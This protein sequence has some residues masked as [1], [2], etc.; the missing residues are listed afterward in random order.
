MKY[1]NYGDRTD[2]LQSFRKARSVVIEGHKLLIFADLSAGVS[3]KRKDFQPV[4][5][6]LFKCNVNF[7][8][9]YPAVLCLQAL[10]GEQLTF[11]SPDKATAFLCILLSLTKPP[12]S[13]TYAEKVKSGLRE[14]RSPR[15]DLPKH[16]KHTYSLL[17]ESP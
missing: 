4:C 8:L 16:L 1:L 9:A 2:I 15:K 14:Q 3:Q 12:S 17:K 7:T 11:Q 6:E 5:A 13:D 10:D